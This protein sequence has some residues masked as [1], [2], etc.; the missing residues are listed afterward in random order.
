[1]AELIN[2][3]NIVLYYYDETTY[4]DVPFACATASTL[5]I[6]TETREITSQ[7]SAFF[8]EFQP[9]VI[10]WNISASGFMILSTQYNYLAILGLVTNRTMFTAKFVI[11]NGTV[12]G[13]SIFTGRVVITSLTL[14]VQDDQLGTYSLELQGSGQYSIAGTTVT[15]GGI[16]ITGGSI[17]Q[18]FQAT[19]T[20]G[21]TSITF[22]GAI[23]LE[24]LYGSRGGIAIQPIGTLTG[25]GGTWD[26]ATGVLTLA[27]P[28]VDGEQILILAQ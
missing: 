2:G 26:I 4:Q 1:M 25:N 3:R 21:Q 18:V 16:I 19:A 27:T 24:L 7:T 23:G 17:V 11:D 20:E 9:D 12:F 28:A 8:R 14:D 22:A 6:Q 15:P 13:L 10:S 5:A